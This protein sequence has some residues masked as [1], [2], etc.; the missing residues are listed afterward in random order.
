M[1]QREGYGIPPGGVPMSGVDFWL[2]PD[3]ETGRIGDMCVCN[4]GLK[5]SLGPHDGLL[6]KAGERTEAKR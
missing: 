4:C 2:G 3:Q 1:K 6:A 5:A